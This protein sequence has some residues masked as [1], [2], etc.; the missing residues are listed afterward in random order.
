M[1]RNENG[2]KHHRHGH[3]AQRAVLRK[4][5]LA[6]GRGHGKARGH[7]HVFHRAQK[8]GEVL[9][10]RN[11]RKPLHNGPR[12]QVRL[13]RRAQ[14]APGPAP[15]R[16]H[17]APACRLAYRVAHHGGGAG[18]RKAVGHGARQQQHH[19]ADAHRLFK[20]LR[21][22]VGPHAA[23]GQKIAAQ[24]RAKRHKRQAGRQKAQRRHGAQVFQPP[25]GRR[26]RQ[27][28]LR[29]AAQKPQRQ[30]Q[31]Q[32]AAHHRAHGARPPA[33]K[34][35]GAQPRGRDGKARRGQRDGKVIHRKNKLVNAHAPGAKLPRH[36]HAQHHARRAQ[37]KA[38]AR[39]NGRAFHI[40]RFAHAVPPSP[41][42]GTG[43]GDVHMQ[44]MQKKR[45]GAGQ[46]RALGL[47]G[48]RGA[49][50]ASAPACGAGA[51]LPPKKQ[52]GP[53]PGPGAPQFAFARP[54]RAAFFV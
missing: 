37:H 41:F 33:R 42:H 47:A 4:A 45:R 17:I 1:A 26:A 51:C 11:G 14:S 16:H 3:A 7:H 53:R 18:R 9:V 21:Q 39:E 5:H 20:Q 52:A 43:K 32:H 54:G 49:K 22:R 30:G 34:A 50:P 27:G 6:A 31:R 23:H 19:H 46:S 24:H 36:I 13:L 25:L 15:A 10:G 38:R 44:N 40:A 28:K 8:A 29:Q 12:R 2:K 35:L 48:R